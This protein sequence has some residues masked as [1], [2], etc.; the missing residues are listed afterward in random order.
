MKISERGQ[1]TIPK[2]LRDR[3]GLN[4]DVEIEMVSIKEGF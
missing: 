3:F 1:V 2:A 4:K